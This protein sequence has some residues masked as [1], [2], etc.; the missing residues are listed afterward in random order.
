MVS[1]MYELTTLDIAALVTDKLNAVAQPLVLE[2]AQERECLKA[3]VTDHSKHTLSLVEAANT[4]CPSLHKFGEV[5][6]ELMLTASSIQMSARMFQEHTQSLVNST[7]S[8]ES[9]STTLKSDI[10]SLPQSTHVTY[11]SVA[12]NSV[13]PP[14]T[15]STNNPNLYGINQSNAS[16]HPVYIQRIINRLSIT[17]KQIYIMF[18]PSDNKAPKEKDG[19]AAQQL[20]T[21]LNTLIKPPASDAS[22]A[23]VSS[24][25]TIWAL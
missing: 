20:G 15:N 25:P 24:I 6:R 7:K 1:K 4:A 11:A 16:N 2:L 21:K 18:S 8:L 13:R 12:S 5:H 22:V 23:A 10:I 9:L 17:E 19:L 14:P 3:L